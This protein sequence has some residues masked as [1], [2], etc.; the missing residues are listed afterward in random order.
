[1]AAVSDGTTNKSVIIINFEDVNQAYNKHTDD[2]SYGRSYVESMWGGI[3]TGVD[4]FGGADDYV[5]FLAFYK[6]ELDLTLV[7]VTSHKK[8]ITIHAMASK[9]ITLQ[10]GVNSVNVSDIITLVNYFKTGNGVQDGPWK[11]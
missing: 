6:G 9:D 11:A 1:M 5:E 2:G 3:L 4:S 7:K 8:G 10:V